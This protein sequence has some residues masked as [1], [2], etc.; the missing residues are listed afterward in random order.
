MRKYL[1]WTVIL[2]GLL[3]LV[4]LAANFMVGS[5]S[6][7]MIVDAARSRCLADGFS[8]EKMMVTEVYVDNGLFGFGGRASIE[9]TRTG[10]G[11]WPE[12]VPGLLRVELRRRMNLA[13]ADWTVISVQSE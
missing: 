3:V 9:F 5:G 6:S 7:T 2:V 10:L 12:N 1:L 8:A 13:R 4:F 11:P